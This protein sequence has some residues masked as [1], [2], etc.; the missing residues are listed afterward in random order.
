MAACGVMIRAW[1]SLLA[2]GGPDAGRDQLETGAERRAQRR[3]FDRRA[4]HAVEPALRGESREPAAPAAAAPSCTPVSRRSAS[5]RLVSTVTA[6]S[7]G[8][9]PCSSRR[10]SAHRVARG[11][12]HRAA[13]AGVH[14]QHPDAEPRRRG[15]GL[16]DGVRNV[17]E[18]EIEKDA[19]AALDHP[20]HGL[21]TG[22]DEHLLADL[23]RAGA[24]DRAGRP[25]P[26]R[27]S[28][29][30]NRARR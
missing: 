13:A 12:E 1:S 22:D 9:R 19:K 16:G 27:A 23:E 30:R 24:P 29:W 15:A 28:G 4:D 2:A 14:V 6:I 11:L 25:A 18:L 7:S 10:P 20:A 3:R 5:T 26:A 21:R 8:A 17:V